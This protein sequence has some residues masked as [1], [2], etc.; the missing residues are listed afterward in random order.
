MKL[1][2]GRI[3]NYKLSQYDIEE[4]IIMA[5]EHDYSFGDPQPGDVIPA[6]VVKV[7]SDGLSFNGKAFLDGEPDLWVTSVTE[8][9]H[10][11]QWHWP[12]IDKPAAPNN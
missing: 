2:P 8:G 5:K 10:P 1:T 4:L 7:H 9:A 6:I 12:V 11:G 3:V